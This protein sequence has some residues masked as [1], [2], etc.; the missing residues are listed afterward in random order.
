MKTDGS[1]FTSN[2]YYIPDVMYI[3]NGNGTFTD[4]I[5]EKTKQISFYGMGVDMEDINNDGHQ[6][7]FVLDMASNDHVRSKTLMASMNVP[8]FNLLTETLGFQQQYMYNSLQLNVGN[9]TFHNIAQ[10]SKLS[11][12]DWSWAGLMVD[13]NNDELKE[14]YVTN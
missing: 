5:K 11:K 10:F 8:R 9:A 1:I 2:D 14:I 12:T 7:I 3:N 13:L 4:R 6:D